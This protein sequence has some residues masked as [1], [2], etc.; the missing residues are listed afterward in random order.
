HSMSLDGYF[1]PIPGLVLLMPS[2]S[3]DIHG[4]M[5]TAGDYDGPVV[6]LEPKWMYRQTL[7]PA[8][9]GEPQDAVGVAELK[10]RIMRGEVPELPDVRVPFGKGVVRRAGTDLT[11]VS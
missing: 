8:F 6:L 2:T 1:A 10:K 9:P 11:I 3:F 7:G 5:L 4:L